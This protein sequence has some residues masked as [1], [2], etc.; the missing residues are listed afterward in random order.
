MSRNRLSG[1]VRGSPPWRLRNFSAA[2]ST[3]RTL[4]VF[5]NAATTANNGSTDAGVAYQFASSFSPP[6]DGSLWSGNL[7]RK[8][9][10][11][12]PVSGVMTTQLKDIDPGKGD[13]FAANVN[14]NTGEPRRFFTVIGELDTVLANL[15]RTVARLAGLAAPFMP[16][17]A[18]QIW[19]LL[20]GDTPFER[21]AWSALESPEIQGRRVEKPPVLFPKPAPV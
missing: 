6:P 13:D 7:E 3:S 4:P 21:L 20:G 11:C 8:R 16:E 2:N 19:R 10:V 17:K 1:S 15:V 12:E 5:A 18:A 9:F 14:S